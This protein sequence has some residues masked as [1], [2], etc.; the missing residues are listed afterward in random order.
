MEISGTVPLGGFLALKDSIS[1]FS[2]KDNAWMFFTDAIKGGS[3]SV[4]VSTKVVLLPNPVQEK[5]SQL[6]LRMRALKVC[7]E[8]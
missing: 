3:K 6:V 2:V 5:G 7:Q 1:S 8:I 4:M